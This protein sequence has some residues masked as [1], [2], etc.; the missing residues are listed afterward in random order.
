MDKIKGLFFL[1]KDNG[2]FVV[3]NVFFDVY[4]GEIIGFVGINGLGKLIMF[5]LL[6][7]IILLISGEIEMNG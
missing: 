1:V 7:K 6:V 3:W 2:F 4:E 5:N